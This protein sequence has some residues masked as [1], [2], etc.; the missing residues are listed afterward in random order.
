MQCVGDSKSSRSMKA[1]DPSWQGVVAPE[2]GHLDDAKGGRIFFHTRPNLLPSCFSGPL[3][4]AARTK[5]LAWMDSLVLD[6]PVS[7]GISP[8]Q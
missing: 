5:S 1:R 2:A 6:G 7:P 4:L 8:K 3:R